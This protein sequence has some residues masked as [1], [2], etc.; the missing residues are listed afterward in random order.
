MLVNLETIHLNHDPTAKTTGA[1]SIRRNETI[2]VV[3]PEWRKGRSFRPEDAPAAYVYKVVD[4][5]MKNKVCVAI[6][7][8]FSCTDPSVE[9]VQVQALDGHVHPVNVLGTVP[10]TDVRFVNGKG[11]ATLFLDGVRIPAIGVGVDIVVWKWQFLVDGK[12]WQDITTTVHKVYTVAEIPFAPWDPGSRDINNTQLPWTEV[13]DFA[14]EVAVSKKNVVEAA[15]KITQW[16]NSLGPE[17][18]RY[19]NEGSGWTV[20]SDDPPPRFDCTQ[21]LLL[22]NTRKNLVGRAVNCDDCAAIV[23]SF[24]TILG[25]PLF[26]GEMA[27]DHN[28]RL[29]PNIKIGRDRVSN[30]RF[31]RHNVAWLGNVTQNDRLFDACV[32]LVSN[33]TTPPTFT[34][35][36]NILF[37]DYRPRLTQVNTVHPS[38][39][40]PVRKIGVGA[41]HVP[42][43]TFV[44][45]AI[46]LAAAEIAE[47]DLIDFRVIDTVLA[48]HF[49]QSFWQDRH[50]A[51]IAFSVNMYQVASGKSTKPVLENLLGRFHLQPEK[52]PGLGTEAYATQ[53]GFT[54]VFVRDQ[55][56]FLLRNTGERVV[57]SE[58][59]ARAIDGLIAQ[60]NDD[61]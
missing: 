44:G 27:T 31:G 54:V 39:P 33:A 45:F 21:F 22:L 61:D 40:R 36:V 30:G 8:E 16:A 48:Q 46:L 57:S 2:P 9:Q 49:S 19:D 23:V 7:A 14:C 37:N 47:L 13:L 38:G 56:V 59:F 55:F 18:V 53:H 1:F 29:N 11:T 43:D 34:V 20:F 12:D 17:F 6:K 15:T 52:M 35:P 25:C 51:D 5:L 3:L 26:E 50:E 60:L 41:R 4:E 58:G 32:Q 28:F 42:P 24:S 10:P